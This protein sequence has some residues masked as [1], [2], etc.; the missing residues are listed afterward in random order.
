MSMLK[1]EP[2][3]IQVFGKMRCRA[4]ILDGAGANSRGW[5]QWELQAFAAPLRT[6]D[7]VDG[8]QT[9]SFAPAKAS[10]Y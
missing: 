4:T 6:A 1:R 3:Q 8:V 7:A 9:T 5:E 2:A 10:R